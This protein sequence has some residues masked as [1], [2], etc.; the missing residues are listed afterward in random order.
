MP[1]PRPTP[2]Q[3]PSW[4]DTY[5]KLARQHSKTISRTHYIVGCR[6]AQIWAA[7]T[8]QALV[9]ILVFLVG[10]S[11]LADIAEHSSVTLS[12]S[13]YWLSG[14][15]NAPFPTLLGEVVPFRV[16]D[17]HSGEVSSD[18]VSPPFPRT[19]SRPR[20]KERTKQELVRSSIAVH[21]S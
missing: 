15:R 3:Q 14:I 13:R 6:T 7:P 20:R 9:A 21:P 17:V 19:A 8:G 11:T 10:E 2:L 5:A 18:R 12:R 1:Q 4:R 16:V